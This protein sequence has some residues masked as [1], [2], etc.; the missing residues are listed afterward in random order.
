MTANNI[1][2][3]P[4][5]SLSVCSLV[6][7]SIDIR[8]HPPAYCM[9][10]DASR[11]HLRLLRNKFSSSSSKKYFSIKLSSYVRSNSFELSNFELLN[12]IFRFILLAN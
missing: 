1:Y 6:S 4:T 8:L 3:N 2:S 10:S 9:H 5:L 12:P 7:T 11:G